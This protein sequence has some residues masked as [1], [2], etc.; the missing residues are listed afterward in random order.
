MKKHPPISAV[1]FDVGGT[2]IEP[3]PSVGHLYAEVAR[4]W[5]LAG[6]SPDSLNRAFASTWQSRKPF[7]QSR[8]AWQRLVNQTFAAAGAAQPSHACFD[9]IY[10]RFAQ[11]SAWRVFDDA[12]PALETLQARGFRLGIVSN[13]DERL[14]PLLDEL[15]LSKY[16]R[17]SIISCEA[18]CVK[19]DPKIFMRAAAELECQPAA[20][21]HVG[22]SAREDAAG[23]LVAGTRAV[24]I[25][26]LGSGARHAQT[27]P[28]GPAEGP[29]PFVGGY[30]VISTLLAIPA[31]LESGCADRTLY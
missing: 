1:T 6:A 8:A 2:L 27:E 17:A 22:D 12:L 30:T 21:V 29:P 18:G 9:A 25:D 19:P 15:G 28:A 13:W 26:R 4:Q 11:A 31:S 24:L 16:F 23:A 10:R 7:D 5:G 3:W 20:M 14:R